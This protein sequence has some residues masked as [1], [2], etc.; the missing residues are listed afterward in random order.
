MFTLLLLLTG[1]V[2]GIYNYQQ[3]TRI[4]LGSSEKLFQRIEQDVRSDLKSTYDPIRHLLSLLADNPA[5]QAS[6]LEQRLALLKPFSQSL[7]DNP[8]C[9]S[10]ASISRSSR[11]ASS[12]PARSAR[13]RRWDRGPITSPTSATTREPVTGSPAPGAMPTRS[14]PGPMCFIPPSTSAPPWPGAAA[15]WQ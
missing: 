7:Q 5:A 9:A 13:S 2:L 10:A 15:E 3:T 12:R 8:N 6:N 4:I 1:V 14:P 11:T